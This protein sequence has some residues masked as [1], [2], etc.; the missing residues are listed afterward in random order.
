MERNY[1]CEGI[2][3]GEPVAWYE[4]EY[5]SLVE[6]W[7]WF[8]EKLYPITRRKSEVEHRIDL[9]NGGY[10]EMW[11]LQDKDA[12]RGRH[13]KRVVINEAA[14]VPALDY[15]WNA[16]IRVTLADLRGSAMIGS[17]PKGLNF[18]WQLYKKGDDKLEPEWACFTKTT[19]DNPY[20]PRD[21][22]ED[23]RRSL[24]EIIFQQEI[25]AQFINM[26]GS[27]FR[28]VQEAARLQPLA[29]PLPGHQYIAGVDVAASVDFTVLSVMDA[30]SKEMVFMDRFNRVDYNV[31]IDRL[32]AAYKRWNMTAMKIEAN[33]IGQPVIDNLVSRGI[34]VIPFTTTAA[35]KQVIIQ[36]LQ[37]A[38]E[39]GQIA[40]L[41]D[42]V[43]VGELLSFEAKR[44]ASG[45]FSYSAPEGLHDD[46]VLSLSIAWDAIY[47]RPWL[48]S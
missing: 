6:N 26:E 3:A 46:C 39:N 18:F 47:N 33:S 35:T 32:D 2:L 16:V 5:K 22:L 40:I 44:N 14:K 37:A 20:I 11:S 45:S 27:V 23:M 13:Y 43:L 21:E 48:I 1:A 19:Y 9:T 31:L 17:T 34:H 8:T 41:N 7:S 36:N 12:S 38:F 28:R 10:L 30:G 42:P 4:P 25:L 24:P 15:S 29:A